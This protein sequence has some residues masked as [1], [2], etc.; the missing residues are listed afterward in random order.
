MNYNISAKTKPE[1]SGFLFSK[2]FVQNIKS[3]PIQ[4]Y[5]NIIFILIL[6]LININYDNYDH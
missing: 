6:I 4:K 2:G 5:T 1:P 3:T